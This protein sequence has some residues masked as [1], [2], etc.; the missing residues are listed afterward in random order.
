MSSDRSTGSRTRRWYVQRDAQSLPEL[1]RL[2][3]RAVAIDRLGDGLVRWAPAEDEGQRL[4]GVDGEVGDGGADPRRGAARRRAAPPCRGR[5][6]R[7]ASPSVQAR[8]P[9]NEGAVAEAQHELD[10]AS[11]RRRARPRPCAR[12]GLRAER[13]HEVDDRDRA[14]RASRTSSRGSGCRRDSARSTRVSRRPARCASG[15]ARDCRAARRS[16][17]RNRSAA[18]RASRSIRRARRARRSRSRR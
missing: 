8:D 7:A 9:R 14:A 18:S 4:A 11:P 12:V 6:S 1:L 13:R 5:R 17:R 10:V 16:R 15:R 3:Q 2:A